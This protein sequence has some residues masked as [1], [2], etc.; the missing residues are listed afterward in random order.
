[1]RKV[2]IVFIISAV[3]VILFLFIDHAGIIPWNQIYNPAHKMPDM[4]GLKIDQA[5]VVARIKGLSINVAG[6]IKSTEYDKGVIISQAPEKYVKTKSTTVKVVISK[7]KVQA[8]V[9]E[10]LGLKFDEAV[11][12]ITRQELDTGKKEY[13]NSEKEKGTVLSV[14]PQCGQAVEKGTEINFTVSKGPALVTVPNLIGQRISVAQNLLSG[15]G[16]T[17]G[18]VKKETSI[19]HRFGIIL[20]QWPSPGKKVSKG[21]KV[22]IVLNEEAEEE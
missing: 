17:M 3:T 2:L 5:E 6:E 20:R 21:S 22:N 14:S 19:E 10:V 13:V 4:E 8:K 18:E 9:P 15:R 1:M 12:E 11:A 16:L 7:G